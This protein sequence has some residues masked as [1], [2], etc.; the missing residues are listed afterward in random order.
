VETHISY[1]SVIQC[2]SLSVS[3]FQ[4]DSLLKI[5]PKD[6]D[7]T[8][9]A[10]LETFLADPE[11][12]ELQSHFDWENAGYVEELI[13]SGM[14][15][16]V[17]GEELERRAVNHE[18]YFEGDRHFQ[19]IRESLIDIYNTLAKLEGKQEFESKL[20]ADDRYHENLPFLIKLIE[21]NLDVIVNKYGIAKPGDENVV[22]SEVSKRA[23][24]Y[25]N[26]TGMNDCRE[27]KK[28][29]VSFYNKVAKYLG[30]EERLDK[31]DLCKLCKDCPLPSELRA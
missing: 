17:V 22:G 2:V 21:T 27:I 9:P 7:W 5:V 20:V 15:L 28:G 16:K 23:W 25:F 12:I 31:Y 11:R 26:T 8:D 29:I 3:P 6:D 14:D 18:V 30:R 1:D 13:D 19:D 10:F 4:L 24:K